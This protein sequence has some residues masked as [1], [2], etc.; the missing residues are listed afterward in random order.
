MP[1]IQWRTG[2][3]LLAN[4]SGGGVAGRP[5]RRE[6]CMKSRTT[7]SALGDPPTP[8]IFAPLSPYRRIGE[9]DRPAQ[10]TR[11]NRTA[12]RVRHGQE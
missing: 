10:A 3:S 5:C 6:C 11:D 2:P 4:R 8:L 1:S 7:S 12:R 9:P